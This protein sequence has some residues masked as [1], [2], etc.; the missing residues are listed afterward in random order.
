MKR[1]LLLPAVLTL[2]LAGCG[3]S[4]HSSSSTSG[5]AGNG[6]SAAGSAHQVSLAPAQQAAVAFSTDA[7]SA[8]TTFYK[9]IYEPYQHGALNPAK[10]NPAVYASAGQAAALVSKEIHAAT[11]VADSSP[12]LAQ[13]RAPMKALDEGFKAALVKLKQGRFNVGEIQAA[14]VAISS[15]RGSAQSAGLSIPG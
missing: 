13:L 9:D 12:Q 7:G 15:I 5:S 14:A 2:G 3:S 11:K 1:F 8:F 6:S 10:P 4:S